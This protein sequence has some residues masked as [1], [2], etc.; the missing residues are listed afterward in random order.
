MVQAMLNEERIRLLERRVEKLENA[1][2]YNPFIG[3]RDLPGDEEARKE[4]AKK[5]LALFHEL[6]EMRKEG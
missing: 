2:Q 1:V 6:N 3:L 5:L 4:E